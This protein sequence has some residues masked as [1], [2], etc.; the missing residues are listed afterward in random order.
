MPLDKYQVMNAIL[1]ARQ[2][3]KWEDV[4]DS[5]NGERI[6]FLRWV[7]F[8][9]PE[10]LRFLEAGIEPA[11]MR[12]RDGKLVDPHF[13]YI[14]WCKGIQFAMS[15]IGAYMEPQLVELTTIMPDAFPFSCIIEA[16]ENDMQ[17]GYRIKEGSI[18][19]PD[20]DPALGRYMLSAPI[21]DGPQAL[22]D[23]AKAVV[24]EEEDE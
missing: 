2:S 11:K 18:G 9:N 10:Y 24:N 12:T 20:L 23:Y 16:V 7:S 3:R 5:I 15:P 4:Y 19:A 21:E 22:E 13:N 1:G 17:T 6:N 14:V 8:D